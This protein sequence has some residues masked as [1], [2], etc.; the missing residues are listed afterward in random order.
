M[1]NIE[2]KNVQ[3]WY[4]TTQLQLKELYPYNKTKQLIQKPVNKKSENFLANR[5][6][7]KY[8]KK[9]HKLSDSLLNNPMFVER[10]VEHSSKSK[11][12]F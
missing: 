4:A 1:E 5:G 7:K 11:Q 3:Q 6:N 12:N 10:Q 2:Q 9:L 8:F